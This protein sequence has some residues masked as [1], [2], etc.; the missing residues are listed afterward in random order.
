MRKI[1]VE[2]YGDPGKDFLVAYFNDLPVGFPL[3]VGTDL[4]LP[5]VDTR[6]STAIEKVPAYSHPDKEGNGVRNAT[7]RKEGDER[8]LR[9]AEAHY[10]TGVRLF[11]AEDLD[12]AIRE[13]EKTLSLDPGHPKARRDIE[14]ARRLKGKI[15][16][17][18]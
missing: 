12:G 13:W 1:A 3:S 18:K 8:K 16:S 17:P 5:D 6:S 2:V 11:L 15:D 9:E 10:A 4:L 7:E 14:K